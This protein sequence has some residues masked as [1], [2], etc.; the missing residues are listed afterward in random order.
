M[1]L[2]FVLKLATDCSIE[3]SEESIQQFLG[4]LIKKGELNFTQS[5]NHIFFKYFKD[6]IENG[7]IIL[8]T[9]MCLIYSKKNFKIK[10]K[11]K[12]LQFQKNL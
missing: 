11:K 9:S 4:E 10:K 1:A 5:L 6:E 7:S 12:I 2:K 8:S 3:T